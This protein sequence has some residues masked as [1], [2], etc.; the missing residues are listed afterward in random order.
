ML[1]SCNQT[2]VLLISLLFK[3]SH[4]SLSHLSPNMRN[5][6][7]FPCSAY[8][9]KLIIII[10]KNAVLLST[11]LSHGQETKLFIFCLAYILENCLCPGKTER[12]F[13]FTRVRGSLTLSSLPR[14]TMTQLWRR[15]PHF[16]AAVLT[17]APLI[18]QLFF[19]VGPLLVQHARAVYYSTGLSSSS[20]RRICDHHP[21]PV[22]V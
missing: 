3:T 18:E 4:S 1:I 6:D 13:R 21:G 15:V 11:Y 9:L 19:C 16:G 17:A 22:S 7:L 5:T 8:V 12:C 20:G 10:R 14:Q 2:I